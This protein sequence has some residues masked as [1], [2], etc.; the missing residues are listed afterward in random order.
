MMYEMHGVM[1]FLKINEIMLYEFIMYVNRICEISLKCIFASENKSLTTAGG[2]TKSRTAV[3]EYVCLQ[4]LLRMFPL[5]IPVLLFE[6][7]STGKY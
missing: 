1:M 4:T 2:V 7:N 6:E 5:G 3:E